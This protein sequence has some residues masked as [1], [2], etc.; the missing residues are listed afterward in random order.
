MNTVA[1]G[2][3]PRERCKEAPPTVARG[4]VPRERSFSVDCDRQIAIRTT[5]RRIPQHGG[6]SSADVAADTFI[7][8]VA[9][10]PVPREPMINRDMARDRPSPYGL[11]GRRIPERIE[12]TTVVQAR[13]SPNGQDLAI[14]TYRGDEG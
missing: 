8:T 1:R 5:T 11:K 4:P 9:R 7:F 3:V 13:Q 2:P 14:L 10:G 6:L 12:P